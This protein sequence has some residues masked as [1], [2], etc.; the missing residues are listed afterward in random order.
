MKVAFIGAVAISRTLLAAIVAH[1]AAQLVGVVGRKASA[2]NADFAALDDIAAAAGVPLLHADGLEQDAIADWLTARAPDVVFCCG[3]SYLLGP[4]LLAVAPMGVVGFHP[5]A[6]PNNRGRHP[7][8]WALALGLEQTASTFFLMDAGADTGDIISQV[9]VTILPEDDAGSL[10]RKVADTAAGQVGAIIG[11]MAAGTLER[12]AQQPGSGNSWRRR[13]KVDGQIDWRMSATVIHNLVRALAAP[14]PGAHCVYRGA[15]IK[16]W[17]SRVVAG[18]ARNIEPGKV[19]D[20]V[21]EGVVVKC[22]E[23][24]ILLSRH[25]F[26]HLPAVGSYL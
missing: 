24:A 7:L 1:D 16:I 14:Y 6:L 15:E 17:Q 9:P 19:L 8:I 25:E 26:S 13:G 4:R 2:F 10:Y 23:G 21:P 5:A 18:G 20:C 22:G 11:H 12:R 3:W